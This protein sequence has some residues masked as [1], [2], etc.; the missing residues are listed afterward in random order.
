MATTQEETR[1]CPFC[2]EDIKSEA[3]K[4]KHCHSA[5][6]PDHPDHEGVCPYCKE[7]INPEAIKCKHCQ[8]SLI[9]GSQGITDSGYGYSGQQD[10]I[11]MQVQPTSISE[12]GEW[13]HTFADEQTSTAPGATA[14][15]IGLP[16]FGGFGGIDQLG[17][18]GC[19][20]SRCCVRYGMC[21][22]PTPRGRSC[23]FCCVKD[24][25]CTK[26]IWPW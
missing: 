22:I 2:K 14:M 1:T 3:I 7:T 5:V 20:K 6:A 8:S 12:S 4:C 9:E 10:P 25:S 13:I 19:W 11:G 21:C 24:K 26:C 16:E 17:A 18:W 23:W 15:A